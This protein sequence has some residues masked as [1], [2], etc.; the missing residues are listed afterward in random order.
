MLYVFY[1]TDYEAINKQKRSVIAEAGEAEV[2]SYDSDEVTTD[3]IDEH[4][5]SQ[6]LFSAKSIVVLEDV[7][8]DKEVK[9]HLFDSL[10]E[11]VESPNLFILKETELKKG[12]IKKLKKHADKLEEFSA[13]EVKGD[14]YKIFSLTDALG[15]RDTK[16][17]WVEYRKALTKEPIERIYP[18]LHW[19]IKNMMLAKQTSSAKEAGMSAYPYKKATQFAGNFSEGELKKLSR[20][21]VTIYHEGRLGEYDM[22]AEMERCLLEL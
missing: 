17:L 7:C 19:Q 1:G 21:L 5:E 14:D 12:D 3:A 6:G 18:M 9:D 16:R 20:R 2:F 4:T 11:L 15:A 13:G 22:E 8:A 10:E